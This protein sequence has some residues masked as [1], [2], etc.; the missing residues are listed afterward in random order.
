MSNTTAI[1]RWIYLIVRDK[2]GLAVI[3]E[4]FDGISNVSERSVIAGFL[5]GGEVNP[6]IPAA[7]QLFDG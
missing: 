3:L 1:K 2:D 6:R 7:G 5:G 4:L